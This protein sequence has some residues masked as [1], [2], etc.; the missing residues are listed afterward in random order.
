[1][2]I[3]KTL[4]VT[5]LAGSM[6]FGAVGCTPAENTPSKTTS[7]ESTVDQQA[8]DKK[9]IVSLIND[10][11]DYSSE[12][13]NLLALQK[14]GT[15]IPAGGSGSQV[16][17]AL[18]DSN[19]KGFEFY[20]TSKD[21]DVAMAYLNMANVSATLYQKAVSGTDVKVSESSVTVDGNKAT[22]DETETGSI[23]TANVSDEVTIDGDGKTVELVKKDGKWK[24]K[25]PTADL[26][27]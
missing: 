3:L 19:L 16:A 23:I 5:L 24:I 26:V 25:A 27:K 13:E 12:E 1:M 2:A 8:Q 4:S 6:L 9:E 10:L 15:S 17:K 20:D 22:Y 21:L 7:A 14:L 11:Y 18:L